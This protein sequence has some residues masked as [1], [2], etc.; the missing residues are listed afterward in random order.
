MRRAYSITLPVLL[1]ICALAHGHPSAAAYKARAGL[2]AS[3]QTREVKVYL[4]ALG[5]NGKR[6]KKIG[7]E[8]SLVAVRR[9][10]K[11]TAAPLRAALDALLSMPR[12]YAPDSSLNNFWGG[13]NLRVRSVS[14]SRGTAVI[15]ITGEGPSIAGICDEPRV[16]SQIEETAKQF[17][18]VRR[19]RVFV[20]DQALAD[21]VR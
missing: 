8:D 3:A 15:R 11:P 2:S 20:N 16:I 18:T 1:S 19:V 12:E 9:K 21:A 7:C 4:V 5:D 14:I 13:N 17:P 10:V 6:G